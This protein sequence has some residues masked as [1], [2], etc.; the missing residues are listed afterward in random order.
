MNTKRAMSYRDAVSRLPE[1]LGINYRVNRKSSPAIE[2]LKATAALKLWFDRGYREVGFGVPCDLAGG[3]F[4]V[5]VLARDADGMVGVEC[6]SRL[7][8]GW[9]RRRVA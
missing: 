3:R 6:V 4:Y 2:Q 8:L 9:L 1:E 5:D 7:H